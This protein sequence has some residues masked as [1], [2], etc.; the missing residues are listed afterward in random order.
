MTAVLPPNR[1]HRV[2]SVPFSPSTASTTE[3]AA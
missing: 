1:C 2:G 3:V